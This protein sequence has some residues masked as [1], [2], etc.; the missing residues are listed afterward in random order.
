MQESA[1]ERSE[2]DYAATR[3]RHE[4]E[5]TAQL[6]LFRE[7][8]YWPRERLRELRQQAL[9]RLLL[10]AC[11]RSPWHRARLQGID[12]ASFSEERLGSI[13][14]MTKTD[15]MANFDA[16]VTDR[17]LTLNRVEDHLA[18]LKADAYLLGSYHAVASGGSSG[19]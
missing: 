8:L 13:P 5:A 18:G 10:V 7:R 19:Q 11:E 17:R 6:P 16:I 1:V 12:V 15:L 2:S 3:Q 4:A 14:P 9:R